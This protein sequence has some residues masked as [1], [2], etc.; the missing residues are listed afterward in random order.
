[1]QTE[2]Q[3]EILGENHHLRRKPSGYW[4]LRVTLDQGEKYVG[5]RVTIGL[6]TCHIDEARVRR[7]LILD[8]L[9][10]QQRIINSE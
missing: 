10:I 7:D 4:Q 8:V 5:K 3:L 6:R 9:K 1:M 2:L